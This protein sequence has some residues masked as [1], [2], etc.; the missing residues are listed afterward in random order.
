LQ[1]VDGFEPVDVGFVWITELAYILN[2]YTP[3][4][5]APV[6]GMV[7]A[8]SIGNLGI[9]SPD[10][11]VN[12]PN[13]YSMAVVATSKNPTRAQDFIDFIRSPQ[14][15]AAYTNGGFQGLSAS[16]ME[17]GKCYSLDRSTTPPTF[18]EWNRV[19]NSCD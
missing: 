14:G 3:A 15:Q 8:Q 12:A 13:T 16:E 19:G 7:G 1:N 9:P 17:G 10:G 6:Q 5:D 2:Q 18:S 11:I 4:T